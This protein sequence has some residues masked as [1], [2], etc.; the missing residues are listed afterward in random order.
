MLSQEFV[1]VV[2]SAF[3]TLLMN[4]AFDKAALTHKGWTPYNYSRVPLNDPQI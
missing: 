4:V 3:M 1:I 2:R